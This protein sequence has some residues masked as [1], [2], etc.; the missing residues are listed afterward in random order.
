MIKTTNLYNKNYFED[1]V[2]SSKTS[3]AGSPVI[4]Y[5]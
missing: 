2:K 4:I 3:L 5:R 1:K